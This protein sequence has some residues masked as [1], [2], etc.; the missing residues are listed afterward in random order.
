[1]AHKGIKPTSYFNLIYYIKN[2]R[3]HPGHL[4]AN[5]PKKTKPWGVVRRISLQPI[6]IQPILKLYLY[7]IEKRNKTL[8]IFKEG[9]IQVC[10]SRICSGEIWL[11]SEAIL[12]QK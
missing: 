12:V 10:L 1:M 3:N 7:P 5:I 6:R 4:N 8:L 9:M 2:L 11:L